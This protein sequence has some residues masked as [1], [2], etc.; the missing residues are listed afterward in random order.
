MGEHF[1]IFPPGEKYTAMRPDSRPIQNQ[2][3]AGLSHYDINELRDRLRHAEGTLDRLHKESLA[4]AQVAEIRGKRMLVVMGMGSSLDVEYLEGAIVGDRV[5]C[6]RQTMQAVDIVRDDVPT[7]SVLSVQRQDGSI[8]EAEVMATLRAFK[9]PEDRND[10][11]GFRQYKKGERIIV[12]ATNQFVIGSLGMPPPAYAHVPA[13]SISWTDVGGQ[14]EAKE[15]L[16]EAIELPYSHPELFKAY[17]QKPTRGVLLHGPSGTGKTLLAKAAATA[18]AKAHGDDVVRGWFYTKGPEVLNK[19]IG[20]TESAIRE[21]FAAGRR[22]YAEYGYP[23]VWFLDECDAL[24]ATRSRGEN[25]SFNATVVPQF[26]AEMD[27]MD[28]QAMLI[29]LATNRPDI[30]DP[31]V[32]RDGRVDRKVLVGRPVQEDARSIFAIHLRDRPIAAESSADEIAELGARELFSTARTVMVPGMDAG[33]QL[34]SLASGALI[35]GV[36]NLATSAAIRR[37]LSSDVGRKKRTKASGITNEDVMHALDRQQAQLRH[38]SL[39]EA[40]REAW[41]KAPVL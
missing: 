33:I 27:G 29:I 9:A 37:D 23:A 6:H 39:E 31:A 15:A 11:S 34:G 18:L 5:R 26:L 12:D 40:M 1:K 19:Y 35:E 22:H 13:F 25:V 3:I 2:A 7:G 28:Q 17:G 20:A 10:P 36:V 32:T 24:L 16:R 8:V 30:L 38:M 14:L 21:V 41:A 4:I